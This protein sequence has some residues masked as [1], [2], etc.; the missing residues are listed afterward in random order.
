MRWRQAQLGLPP[1]DLHQ[2]G[3]K[4]PFL[5]VILLTH[6]LRNNWHDL[7]EPEFNDFGMHPPLVQTTTLAAVGRMSRPDQVRTAHTGVSR[8][9]VGI[10]PLST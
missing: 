8:K 10:A 2:A 5:V 3:L 9:K 1:S 4:S 7:Y 6:R